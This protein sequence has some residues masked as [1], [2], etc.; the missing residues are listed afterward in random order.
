MSLEEYLFSVTMT[1]ITEEC[2]IF[3][4]FTRYGHGSSFTDL[5]CTYTKCISFNSFQIDHN[6]SA[7]PLQALLIDL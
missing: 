6:P 1:S 4:I 5:S 3:A 7:F 2:L